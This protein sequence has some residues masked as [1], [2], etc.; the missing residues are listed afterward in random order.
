MLVYSI[1]TLPT[2]G[3]LFDSTN[4]QITTAPAT[5]VGSMVTYR[6]N[7]NYLGD[8]AFTFSLNDGGTAPDGGPSNIG[9]VSITIGGPTLVHAENF[10]TDPGWTTEGQWAFGQPQ[11]QSGDPASGFSGNFV[12]G[13]NLAGDYPLNMPVHNLTSTAFDCT[14]LTNVTVSFRRWLGVERSAFDFARFQVSNDGTNWTTLFTNSASVTLNEEAW[15]LQEYDISDVADNQA[16]VHLRWVM[17][18]SDNAV[19]YHGWNIDD[20]AIF[21]LVPLPDCTGDT[22][23]DGIVNFTDLNTVLA[24]FGQAGAMLPGDF[25]GDGQVNF[26]DLNT[27]LANF[28]ADCANP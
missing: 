8:D 18:T 17:G 26:T 12:Y 28:G 21:A 24:T 7:F 11:G 27:L 15:S 10:D 3:R 9:S 6:P 16:T 1:E 23:G 19:V 5:I 4:T 22:N 20:V 14:G 2:N 13:Y 25:N